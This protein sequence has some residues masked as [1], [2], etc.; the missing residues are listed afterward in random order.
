M[1][2]KM[3]LTETSKAGGDGGRPTITVAIV[4]RDRAA[5]L[6]EALES[7]CRLE[8]KPDAVLVIDNCSTDDTLEVAESFTDRLPLRSVTRGPVA[9]N[10]ARNA[11]LDE[12]RTEALA[13]TDDDAEP[14][15]TWLTHLEGALIE[16]PD[17][18]AFQ[19]IK[20]NFYPRSFFASLL[21]F[22]SRDVA[23]IRSHEGGFVLSSALIDTCNLTVRIERIRELGVTF[24]PEFT[25]GG[26][27]FFGQCLLDRGERIRFLPECVVY[28]KWPTTLGAYIRARWNSGVARARISEK[29]TLHDPALRRRG[30]SSEI[31]SVLRNR[32]S[33]FGVAKKIAFVSLVAL[34]TVINRAGSHAYR[35]SSRL[36]RT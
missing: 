9:V 35:M 31:R 28:H 6:R 19:G 22:C 25:K 23:N 26:D 20:E 34:G 15:E 5:L 16:E 30:W 12:C 1:R 18:V 17:A 2:R 29:P 3:S 7:I 10:W 13:F 32:M 21:Q 14:D 27:R 33:R 11:A 24:D 36:G 4:T 8:R